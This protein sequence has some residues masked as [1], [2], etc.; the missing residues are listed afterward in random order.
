M[1]PP[2]TTRVPAPLYAAAAVGDLAYQKL[3]QLPA[4]V[5]D[6]GGKAALTTAQLREKA[7]NLNAD[8][9][10][11]KAF[12]TTAE[13]RQKATATLQAANTT[14]ANLRIKANDLDFERLRETARRNAAGAQQRV[15][16]VYSNLVARGERVV[17][18]GVVQAADTV[19][20]DMEATRAA[21]EESPPQGA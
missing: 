20:A 16:E 14:A 10:R 7:A 17:G 3:R 1:T 12:A 2:K 9:L 18:G 21:I 15:A 11:N 19:N 4:V 6:F 8:D 5:A 13:M